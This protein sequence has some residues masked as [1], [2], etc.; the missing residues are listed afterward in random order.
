MQ[1]DNRISDLYQSKRIRTGVNRSSNLCSCY[2]NHKEALQRENKSFQILQATW[3]DQA[4]LYRRKMRKPGNT[5]GL[6]IKSIQDPKGSGR[7]KSAASL[8]L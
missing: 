6:Q 4:A 5:K 7:N 8:N 2:D 3:E 1:R